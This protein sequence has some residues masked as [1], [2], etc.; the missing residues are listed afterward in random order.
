MPLISGLSA[1][2]D[3]Y[4]ALLCDVWGVLHNGKRAYPG[5]PEALSRFRAKGGTV[6]L[7]SNAPRPSAALPAM[8][9]QLGIPHDGY[10][11]ILTSGDATRE[12]LASHEFGRACYH[13]GPERD[14]PLF[15]GTGVSRVG[16]AE[17]EFILVTGPFDDETEGPDDYT[18]RFQRLAARGLPM[19]CANP[20][21]LVERGDRLIY[22]AGALA[23]AYEE[24]GGK[25]V[26]FGKPHGPIYDIAREKL[27]GFRGARVADTHILAVGDGLATDIR[28]ANG[29]GIDAL[30]ITGGVF[31]GECGDD[32]EQPD[33]DK[34]RIVL[35]KHDVNAVGAMARLAW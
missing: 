10:D 28:G 3:N 22:C 21:I 13:I 30:F 31:A 9:E 33:P 1:I 16:E 6:L 26:Y 24:L 8:F 19:I 11:G 25:T 7:L 15:E 35:A 2:A 23:R 29:A 14:L 5:V 12:C 32:P 34:V 27:A 20:D 4:D 17:G 18:E